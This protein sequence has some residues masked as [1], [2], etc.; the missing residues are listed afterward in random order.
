MTSHQA[1]VFI[2]GCKQRGAEDVFLSASSFG[3]KSLAVASVEG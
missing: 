3:A 1:I 2:A